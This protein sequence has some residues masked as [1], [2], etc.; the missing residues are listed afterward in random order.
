MS[1]IVVSAGCMA[2]GVAYFSGLNTGVI[3]G[4][5][6]SNFGS[7]GVSKKDVDFLS[8]FWL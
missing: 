5:F 4:C 6:R 7:L 8:P 1:Y 3:V 2:F